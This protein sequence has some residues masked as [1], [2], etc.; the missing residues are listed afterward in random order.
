MEINRPLQDAADRLSQIRE[1]ELGYTLAARPRY[2]WY[3]PE[4]MPINRWLELF[5]A[6]VNNYE[7]NA[8]T[9]YLADIV[10]KLDESAPKVRAAVILTA[11]IHDLPEDITGTEA[12]DTTYNLS[13]EDHEKREHARLEEIAADPVYPL[14]SE[15]VDLAVRVMKDSKQA[16]PVTEEGFIFNLIERI[17]YMRTALIT[18]NIVKNNEVEEKHKPHLQWMIGN[19]LG[20]HLLYLH[21]VRNMS[22]SVDMQLSHSHNE[23]NEMILA[24]NDTSIQKDIWNVCQKTKQNGQSINPDVQLEAIRSAVHD[25]NQI[26]L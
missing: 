18:W 7:H 14:T 15:Q 24:L 11:S 22:T 23:C 12:G 13:T 20:N 3:R 6:D 26:Y 4:D 5:D 9:A 2:G 17:G 8:L 1:T 21:N 19:I 25:W 10:T 16:I